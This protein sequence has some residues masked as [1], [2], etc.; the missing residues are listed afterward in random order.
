RD[1]VGS[2]I[3]IVGLALG[4]MTCLLVLLYARYEL[5][6]DRFWPDAERIVKLTMTTSVPGQPPRL[7]QAPGVAMPFILQEL[8]QVEAGARMFPRTLRVQYR[9]AQGER[10]ENPI[11][12]F[13]DPDIVRIFP[14]EFIAGQPETA[15]ADRHA[16]VLVESTAKAW[17]GTT[18]VIG[19]EIEVEVP[20]VGAWVSRV[21][22]VVREPPPNSHLHL[23][24]VLMRYS[25]QIFDRQRST[26]E[27]WRDPW[28]R[29]FL[30]LKP[31]ASVGDLSRDLRAL[32]ERRVPPTTMLGD[33]PLRQVITLGAAPLVGLHLNEEL[34]DSLMRPSGSGEQLA[35]L[36][37]VALAVL[38]VAAVNFLNLSLA[39]ATLRQREVALRKVIG[40]SSAEVV[41]QFLLQSLLAA[42]LGVLGALALAEL[43]LPP[44]GEF[45]ARP[46]PAA[47]LWTTAA[48]A[49]LVALLGLGAGA[50][51]ALRMAA[52]RP[53]EAL[54]ANRSTAAAGGTRLRTTLVVAQFALAIGML[55]ALLV[56]QQQY[57]HL[58]AAERHIDTDHVVTLWGLRWPEV[59][60]GAQAFMQEVGGL[61]NVL[62][63]SRSQFVPTRFSL[64]D[65]P[66]RLS[67]RPDAAAALLGAVSIDDTFFDLYR[68]PLLAGRHLGLE[69]ELD[70][71]QGLTVEQL[72][73]RGT[74][75]V[76]DETAARMLGL[77]EPADAVGQTLALTFGTPPRQVPATV[78]GVVRSAR[79]GG[80]TATEGPKYFEQD[81]SQH[82]YFS[83]R[84]RP[85]TLSEVI[86]QVEAIWTRTFPH[87]VFEP[88]ILSERMSQDAAKHQRPTQ[89]FAVA[90][91]I[92]I[93]LSAVGMYALAA[94]AAQRQAREIALRRLMGAS[95]PQ[96]AGLLLWRLTRPVFI[97]ALIACPLAWWALSHW[98][99]Q[100]PS[101]T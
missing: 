2:A 31:G 87:L 63:V 76:I 27:S 7:G 97:A 94:F 52:V 81:R 73:S 98:L 6:Y 96:V 45:L 4:C 3:N 58:Q 21:S 37:A 61:A 53:G 5:S 49:L 48:A 91:L 25:D 14:L 10:R 60:Q 100:Y 9:N 72:A 84:V 77:A 83:I 74:N 15:L 64:R 13:V 12:W 40:A 38:L 29:S 99:A 95:I 23:Q 56:S 44:F 101:R 79:Y 32:V 66:A 11:G 65:V 82:N 55:I 71:A 68:V 17:F 89:A 26:F 88:T 51:P 42:G 18:D 78:V 54:H 22:G 43:L 93:A 70:S 46:V 67:S 28:A 19:R 30:K 85:G 47:G 16:M 34:A 36:V 20:N 50:L 62:A 92:A 86:P 33:V 41:L 75:V 80:L 35:I 39:Q 90:A 57:R 8:P 59:R 1:A 24:T 69:Y